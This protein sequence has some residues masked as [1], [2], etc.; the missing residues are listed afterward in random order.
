MP[1]AET[2]TVSGTLAISNGMP[3]IESGGQTYLIGTIIRLSGFIDG[4]KEGAQVTIEGRAFSVPGN[5]RVKFLMPSKLTLGGKTYDMA[6]PGSNFLFPPRPGQ[7]A[8]MRR[9][10]FL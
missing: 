10:R 6:L 8:P 5:N 1:A 4:L 2:V 3:A 9:P 7:Q